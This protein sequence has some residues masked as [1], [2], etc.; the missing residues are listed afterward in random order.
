MMWRSLNNKEALLSEPG[1]NRRECIL[2]CT[3]PFDALKMI[4]INQGLYRMCPLGTLVL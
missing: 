4:R 2:S 1:R 3:S